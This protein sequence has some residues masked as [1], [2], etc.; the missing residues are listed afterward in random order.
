MLAGIQYLLLRAAA[1]V[2][3]AEAAMLLVQC[4]ALGSR[5]VHQSARWTQAGMPKLGSSASADHPA[6]N[7]PMRPAR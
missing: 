2:I 7:Q 6:T 5:P 4:Q 3:L 1:T